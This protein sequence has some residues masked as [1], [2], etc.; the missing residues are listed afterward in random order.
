MSD[1]LETTLIPEVAGEPETPV[2][3]SI[4]GKIDPQEQAHL[5]FLR[6]RVDQ[7]TMEIGQTEI[8][9]ARLL[10][11]LDSTE[12]QAQQVLAGVAKRLGIAEGTPCQ[13]SPDGVIRLATS[14]G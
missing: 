2:D 4:M 9:K 13:I 3:P 11:S 7:I 14:K 10:G 12:Q 1:V 6:Q 8:R 5:G